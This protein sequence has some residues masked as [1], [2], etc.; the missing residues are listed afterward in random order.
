MQ[1][2]N[3][4]GILC[5]AAGLVH[6]IATLFIPKE[7]QRYREVTSRVQ[8]L[9]FIPLDKSNAGSGGGNTEVGALGVTR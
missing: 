5:S 6:S 9:V 4:K 1:A 8:S 3:T 7:Q 2:K